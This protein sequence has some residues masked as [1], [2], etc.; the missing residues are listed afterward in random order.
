MRGKKSYVIH[1]AFMACIFLLTCGTASSDKGWYYYHD[2]NTISEMTPVGDTVL[3]VTTGG[4]IGF[5]PEPV[6][7]TGTRR[8]PAP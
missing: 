7:P 2:V 5:T 4:L 8:Y 3:C 1:V 6:R